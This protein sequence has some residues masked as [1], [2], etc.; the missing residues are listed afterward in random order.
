MYQFLADHAAQNIQPW[1]TL[2][3]QGHGEAW[4]NNADYIDRQ[5]ARWQTALLG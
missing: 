4:R 2:W 3:L 1:A 5:L